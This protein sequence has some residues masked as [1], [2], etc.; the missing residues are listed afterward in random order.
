M[1]G[2]LTLA[3]VEVLLGSVLPQPELDDDP[4]GRCGA[5]ANGTRPTGCRIRRSRIIVFVEL[6]VICTIVVVRKGEK[7]R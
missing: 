6:V 2:L 4:W 3:G 1:Y 5:E 7:L